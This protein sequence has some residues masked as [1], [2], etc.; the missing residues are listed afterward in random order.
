[1]ESA[2]IRNFHTGGEISDVIDESRTR[3]TKFDVTY[4]VGCKYCIR[5]E[6]SRK[7]FVSQPINSLDGQFGPKPAE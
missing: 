5:T 4:D 3:T 6:A 2:S 7:N 1:M